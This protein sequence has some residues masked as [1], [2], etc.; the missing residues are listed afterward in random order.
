MTEIDYRFREASTASE[1]LSGVDLSGRL[2]VLTGATAG[3]GVATAPAAIMTGLGDELVPE[4][5]VLA[6]ARG[7]V[8]ALRDNHSTFRVFLSGHRCPTS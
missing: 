8:R 5:F 7:S 3:I 4:D 2:M 1:V 6:E